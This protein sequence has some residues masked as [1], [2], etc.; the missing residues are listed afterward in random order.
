VVCACNAGAWR[1]IMAGEPHAPSF[2]RTWAITVSSFSLNFMTPLV[3]VG[4]EPFKIA[5]VAPWIGLRRAAGSALL[6]QMLHTFGLLLSFLTAAVLG[7]AFLPRTPAIVATLA[8]TVIVLTALILLLL[9]GHRRG[10][11]ERTLDLLHR[12]PLVRGL[13]RWLEPRRPTLASLDAQ[14]TQ[15]YHASP[16]R[17][18]QALA[19]EYASRC[20]FM[21][22]Y[23]LIALSVGLD[24]G[25]GRAYVIGGLTQLV[26]NV[27]F[28]V[29]FELGTKE[30]SLYLLFQLLGLDPALGVY[31]A[32]VSRVRDF[33]WIGAG[34]GLIW[35]SGRRPSP[36]GAEVP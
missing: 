5:A 1:L 32:I 27:L 19:L 12:T 8:V 34:I 26:Q 15:F 23:L 20:L 3:N 11:L 30:G 18:F 31:T 17:F 14:I 35:L 16:R 29:P 21:V 25:Y 9:T 10:G 36:A 2:W 22:E 7:L 6:F 33:A 13:A 24:I 4:G 28:V